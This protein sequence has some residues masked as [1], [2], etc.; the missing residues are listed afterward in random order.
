HGGPRETSEPKSVVTLQAGKFAGE[1]YPAQATEQLG[2]V[3]ARRGEQ[4][5]GVVSVEERSQ[6]LA[7]RRFQHNG[8]QGQVRAAGRL[9][10]A[11]QEVVEEIQGRMGL[12]G[13]GPPRDAVQ[14][15]RLS[16]PVSLVARGQ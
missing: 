5:V 2:Q 13:N 15:R 6:S 1:A 9:A 12:N 16:R 14:G 11:R 7:P 3:G 10:E 8:L 4:G